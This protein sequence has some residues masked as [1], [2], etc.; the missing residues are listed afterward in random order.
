MITP[1]WIEWLGYIASVAVS[2]IMRKIKRLRWINLIGAI[3]F[4]EEPV[5]SPKIK[6]LSAV[7]SY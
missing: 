4:G 6:G 1:N 2:L 7:G 3:S 5:G